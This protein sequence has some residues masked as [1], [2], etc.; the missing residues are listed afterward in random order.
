MRSLRSLASGLTLPPPR[1]AHEE[2]IATASMAETYLI[3]KDM[4]QAQEVA[5]YI[6]DVRPHPL[7]TPCTP[8]TPFAQ[9]AHTP[10]TLHP[11]DTPWTPPAHTLH[12]PVPPHPVAGARLPN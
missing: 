8:F 2:A 6:L 11:W 4:K 5:S 12:T 1:F 9:P 7:R 10:Q 3:I